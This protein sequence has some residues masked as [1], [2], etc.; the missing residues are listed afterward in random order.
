[1][2]FFIR[3]TSFNS[4]EGQIDPGS[5]SCTPVSVSGTLGFGTLYEQSCVISGSRLTKRWWTTSMQRQGTG[6]TYSGAV[7]VW[8]VAFEYTAFQ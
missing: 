8:G 7:I 4:G 1:V 2:A 6:A 5:V 3:P